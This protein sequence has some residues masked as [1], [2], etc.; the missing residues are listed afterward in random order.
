MIKWDLWRG[1]YLG[2]QGLTWYLPVPHSLPEVIH[3]AEKIQN[4]PQANYR[5]E[6]RFDI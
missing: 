1:G 4:I 2:R 5:V 3:Q 6:E